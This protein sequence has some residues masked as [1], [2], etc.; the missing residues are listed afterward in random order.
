MEDK[1]NR[2]HHSKAYALHIGNADWASY[3]RSLRSIYILV[4]TDIEVHRI[5]KASQVFFH[6]SYKTNQTPSTNPTNR[7]NS[8]FRSISQPTSQPVDQSIYS[9]N[10]PIHHTIDP[11]TVNNGSRP[12]SL[13]SQHSPRPSLA[14][15]SSSRTPI[16]TSCSPPITTT[17][18]QPT[19]HAQHLR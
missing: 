18:I 7:I 11:S 17:S 19:T 1:Q 13:P 8:S 12:R 16:T 4:N 14:T 10:L 6:Q 5:Y 15:S 3:D 9:I 2:N